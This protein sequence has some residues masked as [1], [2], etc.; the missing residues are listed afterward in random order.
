MGGVEGYG[1]TLD[2]TPSPNVDT[3]APEDVSD[4]SYSKNESWIPTPSPMASP[5]LGGDL[6]DTDASGDVSDESNSEYELWVPVVAGGVA[7][8]A[9]LGL[10]AVGLVLFL[11][12]CRKTAVAQK[13]DPEVE[14]YGGEEKA[15]A[16]AG[17][18]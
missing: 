10:L 2:E 11:S 18:A 4:E 17:K 1:Y 5:S 8:L 12:R 3:E 15:E 16:K 14:V 6:V 7:G 13:I 9:G